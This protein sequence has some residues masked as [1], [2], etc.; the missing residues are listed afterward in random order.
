VD[1]DVDLA[2]VAVALHLDEVV[3]AA[4]AAK[5]GDDALVRALDLGEVET[6][7]H[8]DVLPLA[9]V[10]GDA[11]R[12]R[13]ERRMSSACWRENLGMRAGRWC[14]LPVAM[15]FSTSS[16]QRRRSCL[17]FTEPAWRSAFM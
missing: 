16:T 1:H 13:P 4:D 9:E 11:E 12:L 5:L 2:R 17:L 7:G 8:G 15:R 3:A 14:P 6:L 10:G